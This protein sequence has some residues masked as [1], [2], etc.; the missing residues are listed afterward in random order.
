VRFSFG[1]VTGQCLLPAPW[2][3]RT[4]P[5]LPAAPSPV[6]H[7][8]GCWLAS[9][10]STIR[11]MAFDELLADRVRTCLQHDV[12]V[13][14]RKMCGGLAFM[15]GGPL[16][17]GVCRDGLIARIGAQDMDAATAQPGV[18]PFDMTGRPMRGIVVIDSTVLDGKALDRWIGQARDYVASLP[19]K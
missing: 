9:P 8:D 18:R 5:Q 3:V 19:P 4:A 2:A 6:V 17:F 13:S 15:T 7:A 1:V 10:G 14:E 16:T 12:G 11:G